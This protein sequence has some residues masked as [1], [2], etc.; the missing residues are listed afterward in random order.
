MAIQTTE[1]CNQ[2]TLHLDTMSALE[3]VTEMNREDAGVVQAVESQ[4][5]AI[6]KT[7]EYAA[8]A[9]HAGGR[10]IYTG[11]GTSG[12][13][14]VLDAS[15]C[16]PTFGV[17]AD[18][19]IGVIAGGK[20]ALTHAAEGAEDDMAQA[21]T[22]LQALHLCDKDM[23]IGIAA[24]G[25]TPYVKA[26][27]AYARACGCH[28]A[29]IACCQDSAIGKEADIAIEAVTGPEILTGSTRLKAGTATKMI[30]NMISTAAMV[31]L[32]KTYGNWM[33]DVVPSNAKLHKRA[34]R[35]VS[36][37]AEVPAEEAERAL[38]AAGGRCKTAIAML[39]LGCDA[40]EADVCLQKAD[41]HLRQA[42][43]KA[44]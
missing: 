7:A 18:T 29:A 26:A 2:A 21:E 17:P 25:S 44:V 34:V 35:I 12:R 4:L 36:E 5:T 33:V 11:A 32:G 9:I 23:V 28:T 13:L 14:G 8:E 20:E 43:E 22:D 3:I 38:A 24:S 42:V 37:A 15:E 27:L 31:L 16:P 41:G 19:V 39:L 1:E 6:A 30:L 40:E 10:L